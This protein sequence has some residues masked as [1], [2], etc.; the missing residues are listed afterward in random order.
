MTDRTPPQRWI[1]R[2]RLHAF[3]NYASAALDLDDRHIVLTG[4]N[5]AGKTNMLEAISMLSP[6]RGLRRASFEELAMHGGE[7]VWAVAATVEGG[8]AP[9]DLGTGVP[10]DGADRPRRVRI[11]GADARTVD[12]LGEHIRVLWLTPSMDGLFSGPAADRRRFFD[13][14]VTTLIPGHSSELNAY[15]RAMRQRNRLLTEGGDPEWMLA[16]ET[17]MAAHATAIHFARADTL[18]HLTGLLEPGTDTAFPVA[19]VEFTGLGGFEDGVP[20]STALEG[21]YLDIWK[22]ARKVDQAAGR[23]TIGPHRVDIAVT[24]VLKRMPAHLCSTGEQKALLVNLILA[25]ARLVGQMSGMTPVLLLDEIAAHLDPARRRALY[26][27]L[28]ALGTQC[29]LTGTDPHLFDPLAADA[30]AFVVRDGNLSPQ[31]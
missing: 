3:R 22:K 20:V 30:Q 24:H 29:W 8:G 10:Q 11:N 12:Q 5:G 19:R 28:N 2:L 1:S 27:R 21:A 17:E 18:S 14:L 4:E 16:I 9:V 23:T 15:D 25:H 31:G 7:G 13:R 6:G 26:Q